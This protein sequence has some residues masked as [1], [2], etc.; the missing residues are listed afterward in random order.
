MAKINTA[1]GATGVS[2]SLPGDALRESTSAMA[3]A[4]EVGGHAIQLVNGLSLSKE[5]LYGVREV[6]PAMVEQVPVLSYIGAGYLDRV[7]NAPVASHSIV[8]TLHVFWD[9]YASYALAFFLL[10][11]DNVDS[12]VSW[13]GF[14]LLMVRLIADGPRAWRT[15][16]EWK[17]GKR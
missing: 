15:I 13:G 12:I 11:Y 5:H 10:F 17:N 7:P 9:W 4:G 2:D 16:K 6:G 3:G 14:I 1:V 8:E